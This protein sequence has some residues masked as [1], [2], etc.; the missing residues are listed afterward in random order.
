MGVLLLGFPAGL[1]ILLCRGPVLFV[2]ISF[3]IIIKPGHSLDTISC[4]RGLI[5]SARYISDSF[6][7]TQ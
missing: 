7:S 3:F 5:D 1:A 2:N 4:V 6:K